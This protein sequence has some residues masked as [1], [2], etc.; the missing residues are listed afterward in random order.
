MGGGE[1]HRFVAYQASHAIFI[2]GTDMTFG[3]GLL[4]IGEGMDFSFD[5]V[6]LLRLPFAIVPFSS[7]PIVL[8]SLFNVACRRGVAGGGD[9]H[10]TAKKQY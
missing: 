1:P 8:Q 9:L 7:W 10:P 3:E 6:C 4:G 5:A 2:S